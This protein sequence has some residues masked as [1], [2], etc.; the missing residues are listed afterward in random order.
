VGPGGLGTPAA[1]E[2]TTLRDE[3]G[4]PL[5][6]MRFD[7][8]GIVITPDGDLIVASEGGRGADQQPE[9]RRFGLDGSHR[10]ILPVP[11]RYLIGRN[12]ETFE[13]LALSPSGRNLY[14]IVERPL[15][16]DGQTADTRARL[17][18]LRYTL[19]RDGRFEPV[20]EYF[21][22][23]EAG[24]S[25]DDVGVV[26]LVALSEE[27][28]LVLERGFVAG[29]GNTVRVYRVS[30]AG[31]ADVSAE[32]ALA[33]GGSDPLAK[34][35]LVDLAHCPAAGA[36]SPQPQPNP[37]LDNFEAMTLGP[38]LPGGRRALVLVSDDNGS[39]GQVTRVVVLAIPDE[40]EGPR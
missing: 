32:P 24:R 16:V 39:P 2:V 6:A 25:A 18:V 7:G 17:R 9:I 34:S 12:N 30:V 4:V 21:Y 13:S 1:L 27:T 36:E 38:P 35:L 23:T 8:E 26:E 20:A 33:D 14:T 15:A 40:V 10:E 29:L 28:L 5:D 11:D 19:S 37:L 3:H 31:A 22:L